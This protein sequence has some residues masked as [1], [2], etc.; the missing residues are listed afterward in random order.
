[1][2][3]AAMVLA[4]LVA[5]TIPSCGSSD[6]DNPLTSG[7]SSCDELT[8]GADMADFEG[9]CMKGDTIVASLGYTCKTSGKDL[10]YVSPDEDA[11]EIF[12]GVPGEGAKKG[13]TSEDFFAFMKSC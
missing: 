11:G 3:P 8:E 6:S 9:G 7:V 12:Y 13:S 1:M 5:L 2:K 4:V 10:T